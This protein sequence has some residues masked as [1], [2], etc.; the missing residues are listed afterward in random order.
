MASGRG[1]ATA[2]RLR[3]PADRCVLADLCGLFCCRSSCGGS[4]DVLRCAAARLHL[5][6][7]SRTPAI[8]DLTG[9]LTRNVIGVGVQPLECGPHCGRLRVVAKR[10]NTGIVEL[11]W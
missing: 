11:V 4:G 7:A 3:S 5:A 10:L 9:R 2:A 1:P 8:L 6:S